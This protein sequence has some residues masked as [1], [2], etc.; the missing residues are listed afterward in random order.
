MALPK[1]SEQELNAVGV[2]ML[3]DVPKLEPDAMKAKFE[4]TAKELLA[5]KHNALVDA[6]AAESGAAQL[7]AQAPAGYRGKTVQ[8]VMD[9]L[10]AAGSG[11]AGRKDNP[12][13]VT[14]S[15]TGAYT[16]NETDQKIRSELDQTIIE[17]GAADM[18][19]A[20]YDKE[21]RE[22]DVFDAMPHLYKATLAASKWSGS[23][24]F[25]QTATLSAMD[26]GPAVAA[27]SVLMSAVMCEQTADKA[28][29]E[30]LQEALACVNAGRCVLGAGQITVSVFE[31]PARDLTAL[32]LIK[33][34]VN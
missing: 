17:M 12:H 5:P 25:S 22:T 6:L 31:I 34:L 8:A 15:Q 1:I 19:K 13:G 28:T 20:V 29:N 7:G 18:A 10:G 2:E 30:A 23:G 16:K 4:E 3:D 14:A 9:A 32:W 27:N 33:K 24:T 11:H 21:R 26:G